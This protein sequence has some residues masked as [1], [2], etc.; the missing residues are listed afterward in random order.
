MKTKNFTALACLFLLGFGTTLKAQ[1]RT[2]ST[3]DN[4]ERLEKLYPEMK[5][6]QAA[7]EQQTQNYSLSNAKNS[8][9]TVNI[10]VV[11]HVVY[12][13]SAQNISDAQIISQIDVLNEDF[14]KMNADKVKVPS[15]FTSVAA[16]CNISFCLAKKDPNGNSTTGII[17]KS[18]TTTAFTDDKVKS[19]T[20]GGSTAWNTSKYLNIWVC[21][22]GGGLLG[23]AQF[24][25]GPASTDGVVM[26]YTA[27]GRVGNVNAPYN[28]GRTGTHEV[29]HWLNLR[30]IWGDAS[31]GSDL[32]NDTPTQQTSNYGCPVYPK[33][34]CSNNGDMSMNYMDYVDD[35]CMYMFTTGQASRMNALFSSTGARYSLV[36]SPGCQTAGTTTTTTTSSTSNLVTVGTGAN[37]TGVA[38]YGTYYMDERAQIIVTKAELISGGFTS[39]NKYIKSLAFNALTANPQTM[40]GFTI[41][42]AHTTAASLGTSFLTGSGAVTVYNSN[43]TAASNQWN[44]HNF[45]TAFLYNGIDNVLIDICWNNSAY[46]NNTAV[47]A[48][49]TT[50]Y[51]TL[52]KRSD[53]S[54]SGLC[55]TLSGT[56]S[57]NRPNMKMNFSSSSSVGVKTTETAQSGVEGITSPKESSTVI[58]PN[59]VSDKMTLT[60]IVFEE[61]AAVSFEIFNLY[62]SK[63]MNVELN[64]ASLGENNLE[65]DFAGGKLQSLQNGV[66][67]VSLNINGEK[68]VKKIMLMR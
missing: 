18:T 1:Q 17:R 13:T 12:N 67:F 55:G 9:A 57:Y 22:L 15:A 30:H 51:M 41:K 28:K 11:V 25:G 61:N 21:N 2:C 26:L 3:M 34:T 50:N 59:P 38:P 31:C 53:L 62:G 66:Y 5:A 23:Y 36:S 35:A 29:G 16:D 20:T 40:N 45:S 58:Y 32:V 27:F 6:N 4:Q 48:T 42:L 7:I 54:T 10:P 64:N 49:T 24:P 39:T 65:V 46:N 56:Q 43:F 33:A 52:H 63:V 68:T 19:S 14:R 8:L 37:T 47:Y 60:Y 44:T